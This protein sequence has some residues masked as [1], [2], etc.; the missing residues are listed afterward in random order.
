MRRFQ[1]PTL[2]W[3]DHQQKQAIDTVRP[4]ASKST[5]MVIPRL[6]EAIL[7]D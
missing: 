6:I 5:G 2:E 1:R 7:A 4:M 3:A